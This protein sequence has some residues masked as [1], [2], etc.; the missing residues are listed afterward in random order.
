MKDINPEVDQ[1]T[2]EVSVCMQKI[3]LEL[4]GYKLDPT[5]ELEKG[6]VY[7]SFHL[8]REYFLTTRDALN[9]QRVVGGGSVLRACFEN[10]ADLFYIFR[11]MERTNKYAK[12]YIDSIE[13]YRKAVLALH[14]K[15]IKKVFA[16]RTTK[17]VNRWTNAS[18]DD[19]IKDLSSSLMTIYDMFCYFSHP[20]PASITFMGIPG[21]REGQLNLAKQA[22]CI[23]SIT[24]MA[25][26]I[27]HSN[28]K[29]VTYDELDTLSRKLGIGMS[30]RKSSSS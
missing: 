9:Q 8:G 27:N 7:I 15:D 14:G 12:S 29:S 28:I 25:I 3:L 6:V 10:L 11:T 26:C 21:L 1:I 30:V 13:V 19:R 16:E 20:N 2:K 23:T 18:I 22:N 24:L 4:G 17:Q 5:A